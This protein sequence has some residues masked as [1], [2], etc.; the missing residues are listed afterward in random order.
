MSRSEQFSLWSERAKSESH[1][2]FQGLLDRYLEVTRKASFAS[3]HDPTDWPYEIVAAREALYDWAREIGRG[4]RPEE[5]EALLEFA[6]QLHA[7]GDREVRDNPRTFP[8]DAAWSTEGW[9]LARG[10]RGLVDRLD[11]TLRTANETV[12]RFEAENKR[13]ESDMKEARRK[14]TFELYDALPTHESLGTLRATLLMGEFGDEIKAR[15]KRR[16]DESG[17]CRG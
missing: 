15:N 2:E 6:D 4:L 14:W 1:Q 5:R 13:L 7:F 9:E 8:S 17:I 3:A 10:L 11:R 12:A 16:E